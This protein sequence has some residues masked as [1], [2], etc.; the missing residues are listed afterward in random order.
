M[1]INIEA[2]PELLMSYGPYAVL[3]L[4]ALVVAPRAS[5]RVRDMAEHAPKAVHITTTAVMV[6]TWSIVLLLVVYILFQWS[7]T[8]VY[9]GNLGV[10]NSQDKI[11]PLVDN[12]Y[13]KVEGTQAPKR[14]KWSFVIVSSQD[15]LKDSQHIEFTHYWGA[16]DDDYTDY[17][18]PVG[19]IQNGTVHDF[20]LLSPEQRQAGELYTWSD[21][22][23]R[24][25]LLTPE[26]S[27]EPL[28]KKGINWGWNA[29]ADSH[30]KT[31]QELHE[32]VIDLQ[33]VNRAMQANAR[34]EVRTLSNE[35]LQELKEMAEQPKAE[36]L[37]LKEQ[38]RR[39]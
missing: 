3:I 7:P 19:A 34:R 6:G 24:V 11:Y 37:I 16:S 30:Q 1:D 14:E 29:Y 8:R 33:S 13:L 39:D 21:N 12:M 35:Q 25:A 23:W 28:T 22:Q 18:L 26:P 20:R 2:W 15:A 27:T 9:V 4:F 38:G 5:K 36:Q 32:L 31:Q 10:L 17:L